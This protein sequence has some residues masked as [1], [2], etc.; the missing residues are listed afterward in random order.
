MSPPDDAGVV[1]ASGRGCADADATSAAAH[2]R[3][4]DHHIDHHGRHAAQAAA[5]NSSPATA[6]TMAASPDVLLAGMHHP[7]SGS[8][9][10]G[11]PQS[12]SQQL[13]SR[14]RAGSF[15]AQGSFGSFAGYT[16]DQGMLGAPRRRELPPRAARRKADKDA[17]AAPASIM[18]SSIQRPPPT[19]VVAGPEA[20]PAADR[21]NF[22]EALPHDHF[23]VPA[24]DRVNVMMAVSC[25]LAQSVTVDYL[26]YKISALSRSS[27]QLPQQLRLHGAD[28][29]NSRHDADDQGR[30]RMERDNKAHPALAIEDAYRAAGNLHVHKSAEFG[31]TEEPIFIWERPR[32]LEYYE[33]AFEQLSLRQRADWLHS[34]INVMSEAVSAMTAHLHLQAMIR[35]DW[36]LILLLL[37]DSLVLLTRLI[38]AIFFSIED[39]DD[40]YYVAEELAITA[41][42]GTGG[43]PAHHIFDGHG[44]SVMP[45]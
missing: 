44:N 16:S 15:A 32:Y 6:S 43:H 28:D 27:M 17:S 36:F 13:Q 45:W 21:R 23:V 41:G 29:G 11:A 33:L 24:V 40:P 25:A 14:P 37:M 35:A 5:T 9:S 42:W 12:Q 7:P 34:R 4:V 20:L 3:R 31:L 26:E 18:A 8:G 38:V 22:A 10:A 39:P 19:A 30:G 1:G 2:G